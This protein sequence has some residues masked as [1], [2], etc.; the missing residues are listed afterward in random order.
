MKKM[1]YDEVME[2]VKDLHCNEWFQFRSCQAYYS[3]PK[4]TSNGTF[5][6][7]KSYHTIVALVDIDNQVV[8]RLGKWSTTTSK[9][10][11]Q[12][13]RAFYPAYEQVQF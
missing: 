10:T 2:I 11:T 1:S 13:S 5:I 8:Y 4:T 9:Q 3:G 7:F 6:L 12:F